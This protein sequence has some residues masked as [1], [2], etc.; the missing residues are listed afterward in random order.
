M[1]RIQGG[2]EAGAN[3]EGPLCPEQPRVSGLL[4]TSS[5]VGSLIM[6]PGTWAFS[7]LQFAAW[8]LVTHT[9]SRSQL[10]TVLFLC[11]GGSRVLLLGAA[12]S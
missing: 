11:P 12:W 7:D 2:V 5:W 4:M 6:A 3:L 10:E 9:V 8:G 1:G